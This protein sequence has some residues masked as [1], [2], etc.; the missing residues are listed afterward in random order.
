MPQVFKHLA[1]MLIKLGGIEEV[2]AML[3]AAL[4]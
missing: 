2:N 4:E 3:L 1:T